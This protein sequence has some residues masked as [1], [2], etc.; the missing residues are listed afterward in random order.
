VGPEHDHCI[1]EW[2]D[3]RIS[4][5]LPK[6]AYRRANEASCVVDL[7]SILSYNQLE[8]TTLFES[9][10]YSMK[11]QHEITTSVEKA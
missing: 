4:V 2:Q 6:Y 8:R 9:S 10:Y 11:E 1:I 3:S 5:A 7:H